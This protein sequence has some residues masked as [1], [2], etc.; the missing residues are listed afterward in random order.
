MTYGNQWDFC[1]YLYAP[2]LN[3]K[4]RNL[5]MIFIASIVDLSMFISYISWRCLFTKYPL[6]K[7][8]MLAPI[9]KNVDTK[10]KTF[11]SSFTVAQL[12]KWV[13][14]GL[15]KY[16]GWSKSFI[17]MQSI[18]LD[19]HPCFLI[20]ITI[21]KICP[22]CFPWASESHFWFSTI[23]FFKSKPHIKLYA[24]Y[25]HEGIASLCF[26]DDCLPPSLIPVHVMISV[27]FSNYTLYFC[28]ML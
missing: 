22:T 16:T 9:L 10:K 20:C 15:K 28:K 11:T 27:L 26:E 12:W 24:F 1:L 25:Q 2:A 7:S 5:F 14:M 8:T 3:F 4:S 6:S 19:Y 23:F 18:P 13:T 17:A 21:I